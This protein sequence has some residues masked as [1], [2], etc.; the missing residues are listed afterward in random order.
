MRAVNVAKW[1]KWLIAVAVFLLFA[2]LLHYYFIAQYQAVIMKERDRVNL[3]STRLE[4][5]LNSRLV[6]LQVLAT[7]PEVI[8]LAPEDIQRELRRMVA[9]LGFFNAVVFDRN[10]NFIAE[11]APEHHIDQVYDWESFAAAVAGNSVVSNRIVYSGSNNAYVSLRVPVRDAYG[12]TKAVIV[13]G[14]PV[15]EISRIVES[16]SLPNRQELFIIDKYVQI[17]HN[18]PD[19]SGSL[20]NDKVQQLQLDFMNSQNGEIINKPVFDN[21]EKKYIYTDLD[22]T[23]WRIVMA[24]PKYN[25]YMAMLRNSLADA[26]IF[27]LTLLVILLLYRTLQDAKHHQTEVERLRL[28]R[29]SCVNQLAAGIVHEIRNPLTSIK[30]FLQ[31]IM[32]KQR[33]SVMQ[34]YLDVMFGEIERMERLISEFQM[35]A[36][37][38]K[39]G[40]L[41][42]IN[43]AKTISNVILLME[44]QA[45]NKNAVLDY[46]TEQT[47]WVYGDES[48]IKQV[49]INLVRNAIEAVGE[50]GE[51]HVSLSVAPGTATVTVRDNGTG[52][53][54]DILNRLG[55]PFYTTKEHGTGLGLSICYSII[56][57]HGGNV[58]IDSKVGEGTAISVSLPCISEF[59]PDVPA[60]PTVG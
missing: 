17:I 25:L 26:S 39:T 53:P 7:D 48:Q 59:S 24:M 57:S 32:R 60:S 30:G 44:S 54:E 51:I 8:R 52:I 6:A 18:P 55:T 9:L 37:P 49:L 1:A 19:V 50:K 4:L 38:A 15:Q 36:R 27:F 47:A 23:D 20:E 43:L 33:E 46:Y 28:E 12:E 40:H 21:V 14:M 45:V 31:L 42:K 3:V 41:V 10:G 58:K 11:G 5:H 2:G 22:N 13:A 29:L 35:L 16:M 34:S 56:N